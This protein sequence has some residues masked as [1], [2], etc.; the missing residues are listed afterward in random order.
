MTLAINKRL[1]GISL[2]FILLLFVALVKEWYLVVGIPLV[3]FTVYAILYQPKWALFMVAFFV[4]LSIN[5]NDLF[6]SPMALFVPTEPILI[7]LMVIYFF[8]HSVHNIF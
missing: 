8:V 7:A 4:P 3:I 1:L 6:A 5:T 2:A